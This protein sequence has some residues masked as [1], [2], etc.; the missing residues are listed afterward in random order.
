MSAPEGIDLALSFVQ[1]RPASAAEVLGELE[2]AITA[3]FLDTTP[4]RIA[5][6]AFSL[7]HVD[8][9]AAALARMNPAQG[10]ALVRALSYADALTVLRLMGVAA[11][12]ALFKELPVRFADEITTSLQYPLDTVGA[13]M[14][15]SLPALPA[16]STVAE[17]L[18]YLRRRDRAI[19]A[20]LFVLGEGRTLAG[21]VEVGALLRAGTTAQLR[22]LMSTEMQPISNRAR[23]TIVADRSA[24]DVYGLLPVAGRK[25]NVLGALSRAQLRQGL[26]SLN[27]DH[28]GHGVE[29]VGS[30]IFSALLVSAAGLLRAASSG[31]R[32]NG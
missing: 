26:L 28:T 14:D 17:A 18:A 29:S 13:W 15:P 30:R 7:M 3:H 23:L 24:W 10:A 20:H 31:I 25:G 4:A 21:C 2:P 22:E 32:R 9:A 19:Q 5:A 12:D 8:D 1:S 27:A 6:P 16:Q 11:R